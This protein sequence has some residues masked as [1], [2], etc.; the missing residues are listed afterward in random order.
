MMR[1]IQVLFQRIF[2]TGERHISMILVRKEDR[3]EA[4]LPT[5]LMSEHYDSG[6][7]RERLL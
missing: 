6:I 7:N 5:F 3:I 2:C 1:K 4:H